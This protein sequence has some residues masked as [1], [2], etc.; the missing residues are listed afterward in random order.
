MLA[1]ITAALQPLVSPVPT[2]DTLRARFRRVVK[3]AETKI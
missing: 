2:P 1:I 3:S